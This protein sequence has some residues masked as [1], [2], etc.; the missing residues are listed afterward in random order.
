MSLVIV[1]YGMGNLGSVR[2]SLEDCGATVVVSRDVEVVLAADSLVLPGVGAFAEGM[3]NLQALGLTQAIQSAV[4]DGCPLLG[5]C[6]GMQLLA[7]EGLEGGRVPGLGLIPGSIQPL[8]PTDASLRIPH[9]GWNE[10]CMVPS[11]PSNNRPITQG[12]ANCSDF[13]F[14]HSFHFCTEDPQHIAATTPYGE[15]FTSMVLRDNVLGTQFHPEKSSRCG[16]Q[17]LT[18]FLLHARAP[19]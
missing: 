12:I 3:Q 16:S 7:D 18:N 1:D 6:L 13:Y 17:L 10:V 15:D 11:D 14:V 8:R 2:R 4:A 5:I 9:V 19:C